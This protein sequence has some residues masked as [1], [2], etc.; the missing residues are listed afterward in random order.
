LNTKPIPSQILFTLTDKMKINSILA[1]LA[2]IVPII[3]QHV[4]PAVDVPF[5][6][7]PDQYKCNVYSNGDHCIVSL[8]TAFWS[9]SA[10]FHR[11][12]RCFSG[13]SRTFGCID[14]DPACRCFNLVIRRAVWDLALDCGTKYCPKMRGFVAYEADTCDCVYKRILTRPG[15]PMRTSFVA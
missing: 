15:L 8:S 10:N 4:L 11:Q 6:P 14:G 12:A 5:V 7:E 13:A 9:Q 1:A 3:A 2:L